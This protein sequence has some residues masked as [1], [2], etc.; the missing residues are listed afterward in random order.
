MNK[1]Q[2]LPANCTSSKRHL[3]TVEQQ[4]ITQGCVTFLLAGIIAILRL[5]GLIYIYG[6]TS[7]K[8]KKSYYRIT[9]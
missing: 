1:I 7:M 4:L 5:S 9:E 8:V 2:L 6:D 3:T